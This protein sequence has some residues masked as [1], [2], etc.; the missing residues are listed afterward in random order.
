MFDMG[1]TFLLPLTAVGLCSSLASGDHKWQ[2]RCITRKGNRARFQVMVD[3]ATGSAPLQ[4]HHNGR[5]S[6]SNHQPRECLLSRLIRQRSKKTSKPRATGLCAGNSPETGES[7][8]NFQELPMTRARSMQ[9]VKVRGQRSKVKVTT[10]LNGF[11]AVTPV[12]IHK[13]WWNDA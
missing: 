6:V 2:Q 12:W 11:R 10:Q 13:W 4:W 9:K 8:W 5:D 3:M 1:G 7:S